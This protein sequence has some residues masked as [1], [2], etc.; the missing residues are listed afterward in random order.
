VT[1][2][3][4]RPPT[5]GY[6]KRPTEVTARVNDGAAGQSPGEHSS[7]PYLPSSG[8]DRR[9]GDA[10]SPRN[11]GRSAG[12]IITVSAAIG[13]PATFLFA[14]P[15]H[16]S[17][18]QTLAVLAM[19]LGVFAWLAPW[20]RWP[21]IATLSLPVAS[22]GFLAAGIYWG[23]EPQT[24][25]LF[26]V[27]IF[28]W[29]G[30]THSPGTSALISPLAAAGYV[31]P[32]VASGGT[33]DQAALALY[34]IPVGVLTGE[35][36][37][38]LANRLRKTEARLRHLD[39]L[40]NEFIGMVAHDMRTPLT[41]IS[42]FIDRLRQDDD[43]PRSDRDES[44]DAIARNAKRA[45]DFVENLLQFAR[46]ESDG[47]HQRPGPFDL[48]ALAYRVADDLGAGQHL[49]AIVL[50]V[51]SDLPKAFADEERNR[52][53]IA[54]LLSNAVKYSP[55]KAPIDVDVG[56]Q[57]DML[58]VAV[59]DHGPGITPDAV[60][61]LFQKFS[62]FQLVGDEKRAAGTG[63]GLYICRRIVEGQGGRIW[64]ETAPGR[65]AMFAYTVPIAD[66]S[67][68]GASR[69]SATPA[70]RERISERST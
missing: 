18:S 23:K 68:N 35:A 14:Q 10:I 48:G 41:V 26:F 50:H 27:V 38:W 55:P 4:K 32:V 2:A 39:Q 6:G 42:G 62:S 59:R 57:G 13:L 65:G 33:F 16:R 61:K 9:V 36:L 54:N 43:L 12:I 31:V 51:D 21:H 60:A 44:I 24:F 1:P 45:S 66:G 63:L 19:A 15:S 34:Y 40:K 47:F 64:V 67:G 30:I 52:Q 7:A 58:R 3:L 70:N 11:L 49:D 69:S 53:V 29:T 22:L 56:R 37:S 25:A 17:T 46:L 8:S 28:A 5:A 20:D